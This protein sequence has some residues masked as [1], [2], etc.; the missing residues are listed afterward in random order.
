MKFNNVGVRGE[1]RGAGH[2][3]DPSE[4]LDGSHERS[5]ANYADYWVGLMM[6]LLKGA[7]APGVLLNRGVSKLGVLNH[8]HHESGELTPTKGIVSP[9]DGIPPPLRRYRRPDSLSRVDGAPRRRRETIVKNPLNGPD[10]VSWKPTPDRRPRVVNLV[11]EGDSPS[12]READGE[13]CRAHSSPPTPSRRLG[14]PRRRR[15]SGT[16][17]VAPGMRPR[18]NTPWLARANA[19]R[20]V[21]LGFGSGCKCQSSASVDADERNRGAQDD[22]GNG[23]GNGANARHG[24]L[25][26]FAG[27]DC[28][29]RADSA[30][31]KEAER[32]PR[33][34]ESTEPRRARPP[35]PSCRAFLTTKVLVTRVDG[36]GAALWQLTDAAG[37]LDP[38][39]DGSRAE[40][41]A[42]GNRGEELELPAP[43]EKIGQRVGG[44][45][46]PEEAE[47]ES[48]LELQHEAVVQD[49]IQPLGPRSALDP[50]LL[51]GS[52]VDAKWDNT[53]GPEKTTRSWTK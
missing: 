29:S 16:P 45:A 26:G 3:G 30:D 22:H 24:T 38:P 17:L 47:D 51:E 15:R 9:D 48:E 34:P 6:E 10:E 39:G 12:T 13:H 21:A 50:R 14:G 27:G 49:L 33:R 23:D 41:P 11:V 35:T 4:N 25:R 18:A 1:P 42:P 46:Q 53:P 44:G 2:A 43:G 32:D 5:P 31:A 40:E 8:L 36:T 52:V 20:S 28:L 37:I 19:P 7:H